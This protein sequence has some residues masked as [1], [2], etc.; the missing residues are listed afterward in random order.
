VVTCP[1][2]EVLCALRRR[3]RE[4]GSDGRPPGI[5]H[6]RAVRDL[7][8]EAL[9]LGDLA[10]KVRYL[11]PLV[12]VCFAILSPACAEDQAAPAAPTLENDEQKTFYALGLAI[13]RNLSTLDLTED[14]M[15]LIQAGLADG[16]LGREAKVDIEVY[17]PQIEPLL[18][19][20]TMAA[21][22]REKAASSAAL[23]AAGKVEGAETTDSG[24][25]YQ[26][27][28][29]GSGETPAATDTVQIHYHGTLRDG[30][31]F[32]SSREQ[33]EPAVVPLGQFVPC[34]SEGI[35]K[36]KVGGKAKLTCPA[37][38]AFGDRGVPGLIPPGAMLVFEVELLDIVDP[39]A[40]AAAA[41]A[42]PAAAPA[43]PESPTP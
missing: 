1:P 35:Q 20:R 40:A 30:T 23:E 22:E 33:G 28:E 27:L 4:A 37:E 2:D 7:A 9:F 5:G 36:M 32:D 25:I 24:L 38:L 12:C 42:D 17:G 16:A 8:A 34:F 10:V 39:A 29:A 3:R 43:T 15:T 6:E 11:L 26:E 41:D 14:E 18:N 19:A 31:V 13:S 21:M